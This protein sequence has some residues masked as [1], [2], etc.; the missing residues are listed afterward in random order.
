ME[1][2]WWHIGLIIALVLAG[3][4]SP[5]ASSLPDGLERVAIDYDFIELGEGHEVMHSPMPDYVV[6]G[7]SKETLATSLAGLIGTLMMFGL[8]YGIGKALKGSSVERDKN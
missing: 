2:K 4:I 7:I 3:V 8:V 5:F 1:L 6:P